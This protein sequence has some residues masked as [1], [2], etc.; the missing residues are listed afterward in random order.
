M[1]IR[2]L[3]L[4]VF[5]GEE[6]L[7]ERDFAEVLVPHADEAFAGVSGVAEIAGFGGIFVEWGSEVAGRSPASAA[8]GGGEEGSS[9]EIGDVGAAP[10]IILKNPDKLTVARGEGIYGKLTSE[11]GIGKEGGEGC[12]EI[13]AGVGID[14]DELGN[15]FVFAGRLPIGKH[16]LTVD[17]TVEIIKILAA[18]K[19]VAVFLHAAIRFGGASKEKIGVYSGDFAETVRFD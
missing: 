17:F 1:K 18:R 7:D 16:R 9:L 11:D 6:L 14:R 2:L 13:G 15:T 12:L 8:A 19:G 5:P 3:V 4:T 10:I